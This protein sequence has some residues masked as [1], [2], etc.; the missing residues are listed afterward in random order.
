MK[1]IIVK[2]HVYVGKQ[3][4]KPVNDAAKE[5]LAMLKVGTTKR[6]TFLE[7][8]LATLRNLGFRVTVIE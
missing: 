6:A 5:V 4:Y 2:N 3:Y 1:E 8:D 7:R